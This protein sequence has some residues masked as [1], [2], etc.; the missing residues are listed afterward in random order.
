MQ[1]VI[2]PTSRNGLINWTKD[3]RLSN[4]MKVYGDDDSKVNN[5]AERLRIH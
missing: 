4:A 3:N 2:E 5:D 1:P